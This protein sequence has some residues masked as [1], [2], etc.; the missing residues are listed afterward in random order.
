ML[1]VVFLFNNVDRLQ[2]SVLPDIVV[3]NV[4]YI[5]F[6]FQYFLCFSRVTEFRDKQTDID[7][8]FPVYVA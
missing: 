2:V 3:G 6:S 8:K 7:E 5:N 4:F 1:R